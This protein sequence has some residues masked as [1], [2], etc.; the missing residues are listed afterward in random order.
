M[1]LITF[2]FSSADDARD[3]VGVW[4]EDDTV[5]DLSATGEDGFV[6]MQALIEGGPAALEKARRLSASA[7]RRP[8]EAVS[9]RAP[10]PV[11]VQM[12]DFMLFEKHVR[13]CARTAQAVAARKRGASQAEIDAIE[14]PMAPDQWYKQPIYYKGNRFA[15][16]GPGED[17]PRPS[18]SRR[19]D[20]ECE[21]GCFLWKGGKNIKAERA[22]E[23]I[24]GFTVF[25]D[26]SAR[27]AQGLEMLGRLGP[28]KGKDFDKANAMG[29]CL[30]PLEDL[31]DYKG[32]EMIVRINGVEMSRG[33]SG[34]M[35]WSF[36]QVIEWVSRDE[37]LHPGEFFGSGTV[38]DG[39][40][41]EFDRYLSDGDVV[42]LEIEK[43]GVLRNRLVH[44]LT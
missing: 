30:V 34:D 4:M 43:I 32:L 38:G 42:E 16:S 27:D 35:Y 10:V 24:F 23:H 26:F 19:M 29:P 14:L 1:R 17:V 44:S 8:M 36:E 21:L 40:G 12:R 9:L 2:R 25:N 20:Y 6:S 33:N 13:Q 22:R 39:C 31:G 3:R 41:L 7:Q 15:V 37:T 28:A 11:P 5:A 18:Y